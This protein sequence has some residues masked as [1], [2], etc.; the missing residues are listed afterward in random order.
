MSD[1]YEVITWRGYR[2]DKMTVAAIQDVEDRLGF[3]LHVEQG[4]YNAGGVSASAG[5]HD[6][7][8]A[9]DV[10]PTAHPATVVK[11]MRSVGFAAWH[12]LPSQGPWGEHIHAVLIGNAK[13][14]PAAARQVDAYERGDNGLASNLH[15]PS[16][17]PS[18]IKPYVYREDWLSMAT[19]DEVKAAFKE[20][21]TE[22]FRDNDGGLPDIG[23]ARIK[24]G[25]GTVT[26]LGNMAQEVHNLA[27]RKSG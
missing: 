12:R 4:S 16:W 10:A 8:G 13:L 18:P 23:R 21:L 19:K 3:A 14:S 25:D 17:R 6:G 1:A 11:A 5:T 27:S 20:A 2:F 22:F 24:R 7:G 26:T 9:V 15:D